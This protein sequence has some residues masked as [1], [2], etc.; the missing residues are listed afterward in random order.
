M[1]AR[2]SR[3]DYYYATIK[4]APGHA[5][6][7]LSQLAAAE[8]NLLAFNAM[9]LGPEHT[10]LMLFPDDVARLAEV[11]EQAGIS[12]TGPQHA[13]LIQGD[14]RLGALA[15]I[16]RKLSGA[17]INVYASHGVTNGSGGYGYLVYVRPDQ[18]S[19]AA[20]VLGV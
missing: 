8:V 6:Q 19:E 11:A 9:P 20:N 10:Q 3:A 17:K 1:A 2:I 13:F 14:D 15:G 4:D 5:Y 12:L 16:H 18:F 7:L